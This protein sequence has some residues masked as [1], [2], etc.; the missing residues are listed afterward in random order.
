MLIYLNLK[1]FLDNSE[2]FLTPINFISR[3]ISFLILVIAFSTPYYQDEVVFVAAQ[4]IEPA[5]LPQLTVGVQ[6][7][8]AYQA[9]MQQFYPQ[10]ALKL[11]DSN[12]SALMDLQAHRIDAVLIDQPVYVAWHKTQSSTTHYTLTAAAVTVKQKQDLNG[13]GNA[14]GIA[15]DNTAL[16]HQINHALQTLKHNGTL[17]TLQQKWFSDVTH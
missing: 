12:M 8:T 13:M 4:P 11:Y 14:I 15:K 7:G 3:S 2:I 9:F 1:F 17:T 6:M 16:Q 5:A 10:T